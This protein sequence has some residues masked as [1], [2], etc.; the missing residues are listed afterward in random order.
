MHC[1]SAD[2]VIHAYSLCASPNQSIQLQAFSYRGPGDPSQ[3]TLHYVVQ[4]SAAK[5]HTQSCSIPS[6]PSG[7]LI[8]GLAA[9]AVQYSEVAPIS[10]ALSVTTAQ[11][12]WQISWTYIGNQTV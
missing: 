12:H 4:T 3:D 7:S 8:T 9:A 10:S 1:C 11:E 5:Q 2:N 6:L